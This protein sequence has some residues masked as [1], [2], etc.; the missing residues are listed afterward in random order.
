MRFQAGDGTPFDI[1]TEW[2][3]VLEWQT[4]SG[5]SPRTTTGDAVLLPAN[6]PHALKAFSGF[7]MVLTMIRFCVAS[8]EEK[9]PTAMVRRLSLNLGF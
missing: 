2:W 5:K 9:I 4:V 1:P 8:A 7:K 3:E 6:Q